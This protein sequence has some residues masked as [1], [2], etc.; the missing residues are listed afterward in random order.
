MLASVSLHTSHFVLAIDLPSDSL[1]VY[2]SVPLTLLAAR[3]LYSLCCYGCDRE[4]RERETERERAVTCIGEDIRV[5]K[6]SAFTVILGL[7][8]GG[9]FPPATEYH[10]IVC[11]ICAV[12]RP[13]WHRSGGRDLTFNRAVVAYS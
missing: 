10:V 2:L 4:R 13:S 7:K 5:C 12:S 3:P 6:A 9:L 1:S 8:P 11:I